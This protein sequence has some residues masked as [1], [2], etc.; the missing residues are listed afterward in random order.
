[1]LFVASQLLD[2]GLQCRTARLTAVACRQCRPPCQRLVCWLVTWLLWAR[3]LADVSGARFYTGW[4]ASKKHRW[5]E[6]VSLIA[7]VLSSS[8]SSGCLQLWKPGN[9]REFVNSGK[10][11]E[12]SGIFT[13]AKWCYHKWWLCYSIA[14][15]VRQHFWRQPWCRMTLS[16]P[17]RL[18]IELTA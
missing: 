12:N 5:C 2:A 3:W 15:A 4:C 11:R 13:H 1:M 6:L 10:F 9:L 16:L 14:C 17:C 7:Y 18:D 8:S